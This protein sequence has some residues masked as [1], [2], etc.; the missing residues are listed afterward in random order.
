MGCRRALVVAG[1]HAA[2]RGAPPVR[3][4]P[5]APLRAAGPA[6]PDERP[7]GPA[8]ADVPGSSTCVGDC[9][10]ADV[11]GSPTCVGDCEGAAEAAGAGRPRQ[12]RPVRQ[13]RRAARDGV[14]PALPGAARQAHRRLAGLLRERRWGPGGGAEAAR[15][16]VP[17]AARAAA[18]RRERS[19]DA[20]RR[21]LPVPL[22][23]LRPRRAGLPRDRAHGPAPDRQ[24]HRGAAGLRDHGDPAEVLGELGLA[25]DRRQLR[26]GALPG[27]VLGRRDRDG[28]VRPH[29]FRGHRRVRGGLLRQ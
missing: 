14:V 4:V 23:R 12:R 15:A 6:V 3:H 27:G 29:L 21:A 26:R 11:P 24:V 19:Q 17:R 8:R 28:D 10:G 13:V 25:H 2:A 16:P 1:A 18:P 5:A 20:G 22:D 7:G 9:E